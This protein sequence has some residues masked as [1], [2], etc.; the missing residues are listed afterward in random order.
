MNRA[1]HFKQA[2]KIMF[3]THFF[4][5][6]GTLFLLAGW[7]HAYE[8]NYGL[9]LNTTAHE[10]TENQAPI[11]RE[12]SFKIPMDQNRVFI[13]V[14]I[15]DVLQKPE[16]QKYPITGNRYPIRSNTTRRPLPK[17]WWEP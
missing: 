6:I 9:S 11:L 8:K 17:N 16:K 14:N 2:A 3:N 13:I 15:R 5:F 10:F 1:P 4:A 7:G 12:V